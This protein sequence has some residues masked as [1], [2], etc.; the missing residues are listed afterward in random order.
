MLRHI[1]LLLTLLLVQ[2]QSTFADIYFKNKSKNITKN[3]FYLEYFQTS[4]YSSF[5]DSL[6]ADA[7]NPSAAAAFALVQTDENVDAD[8][9]A[10]NDATSAQDQGSEYVDGD[11]GENGENDDYVD[12]DEFGANDSIDLPEPMDPPRL[13][14][15]FIGFFTYEQWD[16]LETKLRNFND[17]TQI[18]I[19]VVIVNTL[20][21]YEIAD[22]AQRIGQL[23][24]VGQKDT[25][26]GI[27]IVVKPKTATTQG[28]VFIAVGYGLEGDLTDYEASQIVH[29]ELIPRFKEDQYFEGINAAVDYLFGLLSGE[30]DPI[31]YEP[32]WYEILL[33]KVLPILLLVVI[34]LFGFKRN[35]EGAI[36]Y[37][38]K[39]PLRILGDILTFLLMI[40]LFIF[41]S[42]GSS[43]GGSL[44]SSGSSSSRGGFSGGGGGSFGGGG[45]GGSW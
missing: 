32:T 11:N 20:C 33:F 26:N 34:F 9:A 42:S 24:G 19:Y 18:Q 35:E 27:V 21:G 44:S 16:S 2:T 23:W 40:V 5:N 22:Y 25:D 4:E 37:N 13:F 31:P 10:Q 3:L 1:L 29:D 30:F 8:A 7:S 39:V 12:H 6:N 36:I 28:E 43:G 14:N 38:I 15:D 17:T 41:S 45:A